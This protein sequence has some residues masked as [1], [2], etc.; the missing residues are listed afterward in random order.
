ME[1]QAGWIPAGFGEVSLWRVVRNI[2]AG[3][4]E[5][6]NPKTDDTLRYLR[7]ETVV[8]TRA[9]HRMRREREEARHFPMADFVRRG[10]R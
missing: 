1:A 10:P 4:P 6:W 3:T 8:S 9:A 7:R 5:R 2:V